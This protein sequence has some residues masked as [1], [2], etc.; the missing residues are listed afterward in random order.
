VS[1]R[2]FAFIV[3]VMSPALVPLASCQSLPPAGQVRIDP[4]GIEQVWTPAGS[5]LMGTDDAM[6]RELKALDPPRFV[7]GELPSEQPQHEVHLTAGY[8]IDKY[9]VTN[10]AFRVFVEDGGYHNVDYWSKA[11]WE[12][13][14]KQSISQLPRS[15]LGNVPDHPIVCVS[16]YEAEA[17][18]KWRGGRLPTE[19]EWEYAARGPKSMTYPWG[20]AFDSSRCNVVDSNGLTPVGGYPSGVSWV[21]AF[22]MAGN[23]MEWV[24]D[25]LDSYS[26]DPVENPIGPAI[27][28]VKVEKGGWWSGPFLAARSAYRHFEDPPDYGDI[29]VGFRVVS[30]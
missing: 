9:E 3:V 5:F 2:R 21:G 22:D 8:W 1:L 17:Y 26:A 13:L 29:H 24:Q 20:E 12:W 14:S 15:C 25:W 28:K 10:R 11:G 27:G 19:A 18:A 30:P 23:A 6:I 7:L 4:E 16:W